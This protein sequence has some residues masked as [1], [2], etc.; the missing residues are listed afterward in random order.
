[1][2]RGRKVGEVRRLPDEPGWCAMFLEALALTGNVAAAARLAEVDAAGAYRRRGRDDGFRARWTEVLRAR[3][4]RASGI[5]G[6]GDAPDGVSAPDLGKSGA[7]A[8]AREVAAMGLEARVTSSGAKLARPSTRRWTV[9]WEGKFLHMV[10]GGA[11]VAVA[12]EHIGFSK[13]AIY[14]RRLRD[15]GFAAAYEAAIGIGQVDVQSGLVVHAGRS[16]EPG[17][18]P[19]E[20]WEV[21]NADEAIDKMTVAERLAVAKMNIGRQAAGGGSA[22]RGVPFAHP[23][24]MAIRA[25]EMTADERVELRDSLV[26]KLCKI[27]RKI[28]DERRRNGGLEVGRLVLDP[29]WVWTGEGPPPPMPGQDDDEGWDA[30]Y[31]AGKKEQGKLGGKG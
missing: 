24:P 5:A 15:P 16:W 27:R 13:Q 14:K 26:L 9:K 21:A 10:A 29:G 12:A 25:A 28:M 30:I 1:M 31:E 11:S 22:G 20:P 7:K 19:L 23:D 2:P 8:V 18:Q 3:E 4:A 17:A 6:A